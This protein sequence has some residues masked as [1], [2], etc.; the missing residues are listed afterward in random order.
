M[1]KSQNGSSGEL[2]IFL[3][4]IKTLGSNHT[5]LA[6]KDQGFGKIVNRLELCI[7]YIKIY[8]SLSKRQKEK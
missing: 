2:R 1:S 8:F 5:E 7:F 6:E 3:Y 4:E